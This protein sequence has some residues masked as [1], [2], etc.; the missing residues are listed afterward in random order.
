MIF[1]S[2]EIIAGLY[3]ACI[4][5]SVLL[6]MPSHICQQKRGVIDTPPFHA[7]L[8]FLGLLPVE[9]FRCATHLSG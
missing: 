5:S 4:E 8:V 6:L 1:E 3:S 7:S 9:A 2:L